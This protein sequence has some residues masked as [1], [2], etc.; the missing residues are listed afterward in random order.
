MTD[1]ERTAQEAL[2]SAK[3]AHHRIDGLEE[4]VKD[5]HTLAETMAGMQKEMA[6]MKNDVGE[7]KAS[8]ATITGKPG[9]MW[10]RLIYSIIT[11]LG[12]GLIGALLALILK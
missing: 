3:S 5:I 11:A 6:G 8:V 1:T 12:S 4:E 7:I 2:D 10:N 9:Q